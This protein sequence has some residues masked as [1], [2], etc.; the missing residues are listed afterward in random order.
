MQ[1]RQKHSRYPPKPAPSIEPQDDYEE[2]I[3]EEANYYQMIE[4]S[5]SKQRRSAF[6]PMQV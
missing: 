6:E 4:K 2:V 1:Q 3:E 5:E